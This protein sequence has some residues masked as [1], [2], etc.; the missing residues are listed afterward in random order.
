MKLRRKKVIRKYLLV[1]ILICINTYLIIN[2]IG[3]KITPVINDLVVK[4]VNKSMYAYIF[5]TFN[6]TP[7]IHFSTPKNKKEFR[8]HNDYIN[9]DDFIDFIELIKKHNIDVDIMLEA[10]AKD[11]ALFRLVREIKYKTNYKFIDDTSFIV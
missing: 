5:N 10:K 1:I 8:S 2:Y 7:K 9:C 4:T 11:D 6:S 3:K